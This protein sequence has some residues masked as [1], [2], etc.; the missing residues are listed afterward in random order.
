[1]TGAPFALGYSIQAFRRAIDR[2][3]AVAALAISIVEVGG[4]GLLVLVNVFSH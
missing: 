3:F 4:L 2:G 1:M